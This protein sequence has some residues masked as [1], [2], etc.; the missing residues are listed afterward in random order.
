MCV[1]PN[2]LHKRIGEPDYVEPHS[3][4]TTY[5]NVWITSS[6]ISKY[7]VQNLAHLT[8]FIV[9]SREVDLSLS[10]NVKEHVEASLSASSTEHSP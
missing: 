6:I 7:S 9:C 1:E 8:M 3:L 10:K 2:S 4:A 5:Q